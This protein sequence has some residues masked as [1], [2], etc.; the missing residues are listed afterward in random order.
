MTSDE[1]YQLMKLDVDKLPDE[2]FGGGDLVFSDLIATE[3]LL[4][5]QI[6]GGASYLVMYGYFKFKERYLAEQET[7]RQAELN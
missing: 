7:K 4:K 3:S 2:F 5:S 6:S 1:I